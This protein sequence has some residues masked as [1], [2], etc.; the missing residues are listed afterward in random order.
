MGF[1]V[2]TSLGWMV[3]TSIERDLDQN[4]LYGWTK[5]EWIEREDVGD[6]GLPRFL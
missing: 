6:L 3:W 2:G 5:D 1:I 4:P